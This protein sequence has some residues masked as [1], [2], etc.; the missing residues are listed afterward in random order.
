VSYPIAASSDIV[1]RVQN[2]HDIN[3][4]SLARNTAIGGA[5][6]AGI[7]GLA[8]DRTITAEKVLTGAATGAAIETNKG[9]GVLSI[10]RDTTLGAAVAAGVSGLVGDRTITPQKVISGAA[11]GATIGGVID[12]PKADKVVIIDP[13]TDLSLRLDQRFAIAQ[14]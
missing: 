7:S 6:A 14:Q 2:A 10:L 4:G 5:V 1:T 9:R 8:G 11:A 3:I 13:N 12:R